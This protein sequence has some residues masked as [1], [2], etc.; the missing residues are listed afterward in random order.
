MWQNKLKQELR[1]RLE[2]VHCWWCSFRVERAVCQQQDDFGERSVLPLL[3]FAYL[4]GSAAKHKQHGIYH[5]RLAAAIGA[6]NRG[7]ALRELTAA[8]SLLLPWHLVGLCST[9]EQ[10]LP[11]L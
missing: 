5:V 10:Q 6:D 11:T 3:H 2:H 8:V 4:L 1:I 9:I 7:K